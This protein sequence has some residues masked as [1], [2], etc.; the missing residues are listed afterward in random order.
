MSFI[1][2]MKIVLYILYVDL[3]EY[4][5]VCVGK[6]R[7]PV[8]KGHFLFSDFPAAVNANTVA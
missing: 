2:K 8:K 7:S 6:K 5:Y 1:E 3:Y 4:I